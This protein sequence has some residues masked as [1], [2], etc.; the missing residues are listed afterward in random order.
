MKKIEE[1]TDFPVLDSVSHPIY[2]PKQETEQEKRQGAK[3]QPVQSN[4]RKDKEKNQYVQYTEQVANMKAAQ[5]H[6]VSVSPKQQNRYGERADPFSD[7]I[8]NAQH[9]AASKQAQGKQQTQ[10]HKK[11]AQPTTSDPHN[12]N[13]QQIQSQNQH[14][15]QHDKGMK[16]IKGMKHN[17]NID[18]LGGKRIENGVKK[19]SSDNIA[20]LS[21]IPKGR[22]IPPANVH[23]SNLLQQPIP[24]YQG[25]QMLNY[26]G[27]LNPS[28]NVGQSELV[29]KGSPRINKENP[30]LM[31]SKDE[32]MNDI[33][34]A[35]GIQQKSVFCC[36]IEDDRKAIKVN[37]GT[38]H[39]L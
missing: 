3:R 5:K 18:G 20:D 21:P 4:Q 9:Q 37:C 24:F 23:Q 17:L 38:C 32:E 14:P 1:N 35:Y 34:Q 11:H 26:G 10:A 25:N 15:Q 13:R 33:I 22:A 19:Q 8:P 29:N 2:N 39:I 28:L 16:G 7:Q 6:G 30:F 27:N 12:R 36:V 31:K